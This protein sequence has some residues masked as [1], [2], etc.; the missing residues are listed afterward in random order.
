MKFEVYQGG[1]RGEGAECASME[2]NYSSEI[3][4]VLH[5]WVFLSK[6]HG[7]CA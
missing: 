4:W 3:L 1:M 7:I 5:T 2:E 6:T